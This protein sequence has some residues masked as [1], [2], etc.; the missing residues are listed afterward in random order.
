MYLKFKSLIKKINEFINDYFYDYLCFIY[1]NFL[2]YTI[3]FFLNN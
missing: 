1:L 3:F 2:Y